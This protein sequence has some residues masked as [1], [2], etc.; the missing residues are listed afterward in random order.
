M[1]GSSQEDL[2][3]QAFAHSSSNSL[4][5]SEDRNSYL[6]YLNIKLISSWIWHDCSDKIV[7]NYYQTYKIKIKIHSSI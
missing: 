3:P 7:E 6:A 4:P 1:S 2:C 5:N